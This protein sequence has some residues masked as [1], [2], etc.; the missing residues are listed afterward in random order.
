[1]TFYFF[2]CFQCSYSLQPLKAVYGSTGQNSGTA[3]G[4]RILVSFHK[5]SLYTNIVQMLLANDETQQRTSSL[6]HVIPISELSL[7]VAS[8]LS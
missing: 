2:L 6:F 8:S 1:M 7:P 4:S 5:E 3:A